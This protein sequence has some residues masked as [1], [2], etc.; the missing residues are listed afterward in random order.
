MKSQVLIL[1]FAALCSLSTTSRAQETIHITN[2]EWEPF[3]SEYSYQYGLNSHI[4]TEAFKQEGILV[5]WGF[6]SWSRAY[7][8]AKEGIEWEASCCWRSSEEIAKDFLVSGIVSKTS[9]VF[10][11]L[12]S[13]EFDWQNLSDLKD[14]TIGTTIEYNYGKPFMEAIA[15]K[16]IT[17]QYVPTDDQNYKKLLRERIH[18]FPNDLIVG[19]AQIRNSVSADDVSLF[20]HHPKE[21]EI[22]TLQL[23]ISKN[24]EK[25]QYLLDK[26]DSGLK[27]LKETGLLSTMYKDLRD[28][29]YDKQD[30]K[31][32]E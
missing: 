11:H 25:G 26:F 6:F 21:F 18:I 28:G 20:T 16:K 9:Y 14:L 17:V 27:K 19:Y 10:F 15:D 2:G 4:V 13:M 8:I 12:K 23:L 24:S 3:L 5:K 22:N 1:L 29:K 7:Q 32:Q 31:W 30:V